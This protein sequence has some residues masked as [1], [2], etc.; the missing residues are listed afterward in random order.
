LAVDWSPGEYLESYLIA[1]LQEYSYLAAVSQEMHDALNVEI[2]RVFY[3]S[4]ATAAK[5]PSGI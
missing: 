1:L 5:N 4:V 3:H 2:S